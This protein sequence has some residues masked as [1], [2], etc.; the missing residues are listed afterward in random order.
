MANDVSPHHFPRNGPNNLVSELDLRVWETLFIESLKILNKW[1]Q[2]RDIAHLHG[3]YDQGMGDSS[4]GTH[5]MWIEFFWQKKDWRNLANYKETLMN[6]S[7]IK[8]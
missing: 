3:S 8:Y 4:P 7:S 6:S 2:F 5:E 1:E